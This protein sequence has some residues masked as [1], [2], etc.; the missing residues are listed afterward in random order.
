MGRNQQSV[1][2]VEHRTGRDGAK[3]RDLR[4]A[5][6]DGYYTQGWLNVPSQG[7]HFI[8]DSYAPELM[9]AFDPTKPWIL[10]YNKVHGQMTLSGVLYGMPTDSTP[11]QLAAVF[12]ASMVG[13]HQ[14]VNLCVIPSRALPIHDRAICVA[15]GGRFI[16]RTEWVIHAWFWQPGSVPAFAM[17]RA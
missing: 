9:P 14:H 17:D 4:V 7:Y 10:V 1:Q 8:N 5:E 2:G 13:W 12:P 6:R 11:A 16:A 3:Y 15:H